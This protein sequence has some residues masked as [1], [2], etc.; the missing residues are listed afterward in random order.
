MVTV[1]GI[2]GFGTVGAGTGAAGSLGSASSSRAEPTTAKGVPTSTVSSSDTRIFN[3]TPATGEGTSVSTLSVE[4]SNKGSSRATT[5]PTCFN[6]VVTV[7]SVTDSPKTGIATI[8]D[9]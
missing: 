1:E 9:I 7:P 2:S 8:S 6:Q 4:T 5:S 3:N